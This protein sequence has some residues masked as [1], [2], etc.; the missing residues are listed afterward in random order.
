MLVAIARGHISSAKLLLDSGADINAQDNEGYSALMIAAQKEEL[1]SIGTLLAARAN[2]NIDA[3]N[4]LGETTLMQTA[5]AGN[6][7]IM[8]LLLKA[9]ANPNAQT[10]D[11]NTALMITAFHC[12][13][14]HI[15]CLKLLLNAAADIN[16]NRLIWNLFQLSALDIARVRGKTQCVELLED[17]GNDRR[18][19]GDG[20][21]AFDPYKLVHTMKLFFVQSVKELR[22][23]I[24]F[25]KPYLTDV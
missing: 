23:R 25:I 13:P 5:A 17:A 16:A 4:S 21:C 20:K 15:T 24:S 1:T 12:S 22:F 14:Q 6:A 9:G 2:I 8:E 3:M 7:E 18:W 19:T 10:R 11:G